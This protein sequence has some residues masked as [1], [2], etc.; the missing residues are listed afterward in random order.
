VRRTHPRW[1][2]RSLTA[3]L[4]VTAVALAGCGGSSAVSSGPVNTSPVDTASGTLSILDYPNVWE[5]FTKASASGSSAISSWYSYFGKIWQHDFPRVTIQE[6]T[7][8]NEATEVERTILGVSAGNPPDLIGVDAQLPT[9]VQKGAL[10]NLD[11]YFKAYGI[12]A[13]DFTPALARYARYNGHWYAMPGVNM[14]TVGDL[15]YVPSYVRSAGLNPSSPPRTW[16][17]LF[18]MTK[19]VTKF[20]PNG[21]L[22]RIGFDLIL[23][24]GEAADP[25]LTA[26][27]GSFQYEAGLFCNDPN[28]AW[29]SKTGYN[30]TSPCFE[31]FVA[32]VKKVID[33]YG[34]YNN[35]LKFMSGDPGPWSCSPNDYVKTGKILFS[36]SAFWAGTQFDRCYPTQYALS[37]APTGSGSAASE[38]AID[39]TAWMVAIPKGAQNPG[40]A[41]KFWYD[42]LYKNAVLDGPTTNGYLR[43]QQEQPWIQN[44]LANEA[45]VRQSKHFA[46]NPI[47]TYARIL[48][49]EG[50]RASYAYAQSPVEAQFVEALT[51]AVNAVLLNQKTIP[52]AMQSAQTFI[53]GVEQTNGTTA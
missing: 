32:F 3:T 47:A 50:N 7:V 29:T 25:G 26:G 10:M 35:Y 28:L 31:R 12:T 52:Q 9:L 4:V 22:E 51:T 6:S 8:P 19:K 41:F 37:Y 53:K 5:G 43:P 46:G 40:L 44:L 24:G 14:P 23:P 33:F 16:D 2:H 38:S 1:I 27:S 13:A 15:M 11:P 45:K 21:N 36:V 34:G 17:Q 42:T 18:A 49:T 30:V 39:G 20:A 48:K